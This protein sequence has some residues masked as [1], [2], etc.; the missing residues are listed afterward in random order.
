MGMEVESGNGLRLLRDLAG[1]LASPDV[2]Q[3]L[4]GWV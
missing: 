4:V 1:P 2:S 3:E